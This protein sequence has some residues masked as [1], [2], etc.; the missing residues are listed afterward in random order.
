ML[1]E[2][3]I[4]YAVFFFYLG[5][6]GIELLVNKMNYQYLI[7]K[8]FV[9]KRFPQE[10]MQMKLFHACWFLSLFCEMNLHGKLLGGVAFVLVALVLVMAQLLRWSAILSLGYFWSIDIYEMK[11]HP[12]VTTGPYKILRHP[13]YLAVMT[14]F[15]FLPLLLGCP[16]TLVAGTIGNTLILH[17][18]I[19]LEEKAL[20]EQSNHH[21]HSVFSVKNS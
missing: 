15:I 3:F 13:N 8:F 7:S 5:E 12:V 6:R 9:V 1:T 18:R 14:E 21:Y 10:S 19:N 17:R 16:Y 4:S 11:N 2:T 20:E